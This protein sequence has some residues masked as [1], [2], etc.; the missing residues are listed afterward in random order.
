MGGGGTN[1]RYNL[2]LSVSGRNIF[3]HENLGLPNAILNPATITT[4][5]SATITNAA[6]ASPFFGESTS[7]AGGP[8]GSNAAS[9]LVY[10][11]AS[12]NF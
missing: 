9:R 6:T 2:T 1:H 7:L 4:S 8:F 5:S 12:F 11:Q 3:N 10:L